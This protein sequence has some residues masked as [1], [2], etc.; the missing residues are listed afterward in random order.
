MAE[1]TAVLVKELREKT[2][3][4]MMDCKKALQETAGDFDAAVKYLREKGLSAA[5]KRADRA[6]SRGLIDVRFNEDR[7]QAVLFELNSE[8]DF[9]ARNAKFRALLNQLL[10]HTLARQP[11]DI[12]ELE[13][14]TFSGDESKK[15]ADLV[16]DA[17]AVIGENIVPRRFV[18]FTA[19]AGHLESYIHTGG[20]IGVL[21]EL[22]AGADRNLARDIA[23]HIAAAN[24]RYLERSAV[25]SEQAAAEKEIYKNQ[26]LQDEK[27]K[28]KPADILDKIVE[29]RLNKYYQEI[30]L[31]EQA[32][33]KDPDKKIKDILPEGVTVARFAR[34]QLGA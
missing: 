25:P 7:T 14:Q 33:I 4:G 17:I 20:A 28:N 19:A 15:I 27:N 13:A 6:A 1:I 30:C 31:L 32:F 11:A 10:D 21:A 26:L 18:I 9:V 16:T 24:P 5:A 8:T 12:A 23:M 34:F 3:A 22:S 29:G 2:Q